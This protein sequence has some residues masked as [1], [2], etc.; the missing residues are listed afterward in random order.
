MYYALEPLNYWFGITNSQTGQFCGFVLQDGQ[1]LGLLTHEW[2]LAVSLGFNHSLS[3]KLTLHTGTQ[4]VTETTQGVGISA[5]VLSNAIL[6]K[7]HPFS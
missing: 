1:H 4:L 2:W 7:L 6:R 5:A 3:L